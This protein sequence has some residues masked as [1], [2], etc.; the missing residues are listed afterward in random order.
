MRIRRLLG[1]LVSSMLSIIAVDR[2]LS[3][4]ASP[5][6]PALAG[7]PDSVRTDGAETAFVETGDPNDPTVVFVHGLYLGASSRE[8]VPIVDRL[9]EHYHVIAVDLPGFGRSDRPAITYD[10]DRLADGLVGVLD[11]HTASPVVVT[12]GQALPIVAA[13]SERIDIDRIVAIGPRT[14]RERSRPLL[15]GILST[16][17]VG[18]A[19]HLALSSKPLLRVQLLECLECPANQLSADQLRYAWQSAHQPGSRGAVAAMVGGD[20]DAIADLPTIIDELDTEISLLI[21]DAARY[22]TLS[23]VRDAANRSS[24]GLSVVSTTGAMPHV[25]APDAVATH[26]DTAA[27]LA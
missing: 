9:A 25:T 3:R 8:F 19:A 1:V 2:V 16:P 11:T 23:A 14:E 7:R 26:L 4:L 12:S 20:L 21:G 18:T 6:P 22:P 5:L 27:L 13:A 15:A 10:I 24:V 17:V